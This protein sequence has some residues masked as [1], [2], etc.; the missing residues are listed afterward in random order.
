LKGR[1]ES[2][3]QAAIQNVRGK[4]LKGNEDQLSGRGDLKGEEPEGRDFRVAGGTWD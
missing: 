1:R 3:G 2:E 4:G